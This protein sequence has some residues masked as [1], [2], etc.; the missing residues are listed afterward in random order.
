MDIDIYIYIKKTQLL[1]ISSYFF[2]NVLSERFFCG[3]ICFFGK[4]RLGVDFKKSL[5][6]VLFSQLLTI[7]L[8]PLCIRVPNFHPVCKSDHASLLEISLTSCE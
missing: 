4:N 7:A 1:S 8:P 6:L 2:H 3:E 5:F